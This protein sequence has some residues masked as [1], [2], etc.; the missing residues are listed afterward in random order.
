MASVDSATGL[1]ARL[2][3]LLGFENIWGRLTPSGTPD[4][5]EGDHEEAIR[6]M[7]MAMTRASSQLVLIAYEQVPPAL[8]DIFVSPGE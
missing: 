8:K 3:F 4:E 7:Y 1:E 2:V 5:D 6:K